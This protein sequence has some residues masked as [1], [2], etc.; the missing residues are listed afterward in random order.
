MTKLEDPRRSPEHFLSLIRE[1]QR[2]RLKVYLGFDPR[3]MTDPGANG[4]EPD[5][6]DHV[7]QILTGGMAP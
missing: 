2:G 3:D 4:E 5:L 1:Q 7:W 6:T